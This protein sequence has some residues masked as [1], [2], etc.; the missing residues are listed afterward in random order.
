MDM[1]RFETGAVRQDDSD[2][3]RY[4]LLSPY[5]LEA[6]ANVAK[7]GCK[8]YGE[9]NWAKGIPI[10]NLINHTIN[11]LVKF[12]MHDTEEDH[13]AHALWNLHT[14]IHM[15]KLKPELDDRVEYQKM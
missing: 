12:L 10:R 5:A 7:E 8:K 11:H 2:F 1:R 14:A 3:P 6:L 4:D 15:L 9:F 13:L